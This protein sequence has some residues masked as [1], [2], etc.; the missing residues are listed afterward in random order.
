MNRCAT[1]AA[2]MAGATLL[3]PVHAAAQ[4][5]GDQWTFSVTPYFWFPALDGTLEY[6]GVS[7]K[8]SI[9]VSVDADTLLGDLNFAAM[10]SAEA[11]KGKWLIATDFIYLDLESDSSSVTDVDFNPGPGSVN[12]TTTELNTATETTIKGTIWTLVGGYNLVRESRGSLDVIGGFRYTYLEATTDW[13]L[14]AAVTGPGG[15]S[16]FPRSGSVEKSNDLWDAIAGVR[17]RL[18]LGEGWFVPYYVDVGGGSSFT[19]QGMLGAGYGFKWG[20]VILA[21]RYLYYEQSGDELLQELALGGFGLGAS[22]RF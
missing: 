11:R 1:L 13:Q 9:D 6:A 8:Q 12:V 17:G 7:G 20:D 15:T 3:A 22:F 16:T 10:L 4:A 18:A 19:W 5:G 2:V 21:Y 14:T